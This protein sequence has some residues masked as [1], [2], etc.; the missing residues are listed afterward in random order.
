MSLKC[1]KTIPL[2]VSAV[3]LSV[4][5]TAC[6]HEVPTEGVHRGFEFVVWQ[7]RE[8]WIVGYSGT[9]DVVRI[10]SHIHGLPVAI[11]GEEAFRGGNL[12]R[13]YIADTVRFV[14][15]RAFADNRLASVDIG[16]GVMAIGLGAFENNLLTEIVIPDNWFHGFTGVGIGAFAFSNNRLERVTLGRFTQINTETFSNNQITEV[17]LSY[18]RFISAMAFAHNRLESLVIPDAVEYIG[19]QAFAHNNLTCVYLPDNVEVQSEAF[20][21]ND[22]TDIVIGENV[23]FDTRLA[24]AFPNGFDDFYREHGSRAGTY[25]FDGEQWH[26][27]FR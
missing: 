9:S 22:I 24:P 14:D 10:P 7:D 25:T 23:L 3:L 18:A 19:W 1:G 20:F 27:E 6:Q 17:T 5:L 2:A 16:K 12:Q 4:A 11:I 8:V 13:L 26:V 15:T 21:N